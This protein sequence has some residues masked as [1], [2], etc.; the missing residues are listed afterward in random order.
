MEGFRGRANRC[1][2][3]AF[4][5]VQKSRIYSYRDRKVRHTIMIPIFFMEILLADTTHGATHGTRCISQNIHPATRDI[6]GEEERLQNNVDS[7]N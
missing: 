4:H 5:R 7:E 6:A 3:V 2:T 1:F